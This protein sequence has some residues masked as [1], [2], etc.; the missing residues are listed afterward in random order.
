MYVE[1]K[2]KISVHMYIGLDRASIRLYQD[3]KGLGFTD[4]REPGGWHCIGR[5]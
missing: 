4:S 1:H 5:I 3:V 2:N